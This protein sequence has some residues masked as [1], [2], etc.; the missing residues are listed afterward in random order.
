MT[1]SKDRIL[2]V[3][4]APDTVEVIERTLTAAGYSVLTA[5]G[6][7][8]AVEISS[9]HAIDVVIDGPGRCPESAGSIGPARARETAPTPRC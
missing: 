9:S 8:E 1:L 2:V 4:D 3:D 7:R 6:V 5:P